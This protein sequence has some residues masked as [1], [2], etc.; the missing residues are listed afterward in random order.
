MVLESSSNVDS[1]KSSNKKNKD[2]YIAVQLTLVI[3]FLAI[4]SKF[5]VIVN[6]GQASSCSLV[7]CKNKYSE[8]DFT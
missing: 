2:V 4:L 6:A 8:K 3:V 7:K 1:L 5:F